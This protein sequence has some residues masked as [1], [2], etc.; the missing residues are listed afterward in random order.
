MKSRQ[1]TAD[2]ITHEEAL[3]TRLN[4]EQVEPGD[5]GIEG[6]IENAEHPEGAKRGGYVPLYEENGL[7]VFYDTTAE[8][9]AA[10]DIEE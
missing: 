4:L 10:Y 6:A 7:R 2:L 1:L 5:T 3:A 8:E 9:W